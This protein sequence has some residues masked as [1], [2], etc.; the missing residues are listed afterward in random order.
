MYHK[1]ILHC[2][3]KIFILS[4]CLQR[5]QSFPVKTYIC[6]L[7]N[8]S[9]IE[10]T[11]SIS[12]EDLNKEITGDTRLEFSSRFSVQ[13]ALK[14]SS[15]FEYF[16]S[17][18][19]EIRNK[20]FTQLDTTDAAD[21]FKTRLKIQLINENSTKTSHNPKTFSFAKLNLEKKETYELYSMSGEYQINSAIEGNK[22]FANYK[23][24]EHQKLKYFAPPEKGQF[25]EL[26]KVVEKN[27]NRIK[28]L[29]DKIKMLNDGVVRSPLKK[30]TIAKQ[31]ESANDEINKLNKEINEKEAEIQKGE[32]YD[33]ERQYLLEAIKSTHDIRPIES[34]N[35][36]RNSDSEALILEEVL[37]LTSPSK[38]TQN[39]NKFYSTLYNKL[40][41]FS[42][43]NKILPIEIKNIKKFK[44]LK[45]NDLNQH[46]SGT[47]KLYTSYETCPSCKNAYILFSALRP[48]IKIEITTLSNELRNYI[49]ET[50]FSKK[51][52]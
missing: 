39:N 44:S 40:S 9:I 34:N 18:I 29:E 41:K 10:Q 1:K 46:A 52:N 43:F 50:D 32:I 11:I 30:D 25:S 17:A 35:R 13:Q 22:I 20:V 6:P 16:K 2:I 31:I 14:E 38:L 37:K 28:S 15:E 4:F 51:N 33:G 19:T 3:L 8:N 48:N 24:P 36:V 27:N 45:I 26:K 7:T 42:N 12:Q 49:Y 21:K 47:L 23:E 5:Y